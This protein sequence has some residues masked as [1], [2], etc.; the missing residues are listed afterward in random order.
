MKEASTETRKAAVTND[1]NLYIIGGGMAGLSAAI[2]A[3]KDAG[4]S[5]R[6]IHLFEA[7]DHQGGSLYGE[8]SPDRVYFTRGDWKFNIPTYNC[9]WDALSAIPSEDEPGMSV[10]EEIFQYNRFHKKNAMSRLIHA[11]ARR[12]NA[13]SLG[14]TPKHR[15]RLISLLFTPDILIQNRRV[16]SWFE[17]SF[18]DTNFWKVFFS[19]FA[20]EY[21]NDLAETKRY[22]QRFFHD[23]SDMVSGRAEIVTPYNNFDSM[24]M[25]MVK[26]LK[27][28]GVNFEMGVKVTD[29]DFKSGGKELTVE[30]I[31]CV[32]DGR[33]RAVEVREGDFVFATIGSMIADSRRGTMT[34]APALERGKTDGAWT[35]WENIAKKRPGLGNPTNFCDRIEESAWMMICVN[36]HDPAFFKAYE[37]FTGNKPGQANMV[38]FPDSNW[39]SSVL[40]PDHPHF[41]NQ[42][43]NV[44]IW[45]ACGLKPFEKGNFVK[46]P[47][48][49]CNGV[50]IAT[51]LLHHFGFEKELP[52]IIETSHIIPQMMPYEMSHFLT[53][54]IKDRPPA[55]PKGSTNLGLMGQFVESGE[56]VMLVESSVRSAMIGVYSLLGVDKKVPPVYSAITKDPRVWLKIWPTIAS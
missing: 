43:E 54:K 42:P 47:M 6:N 37:K 56:C 34:E 4:V 49:E 51:E 50:E 8:G 44:Y 27:G 3:I 29:F 21:W 2:F 20:I 35:L 1:T 16:D 15:R 53:R 45:L 55:V 9:L 52:K 10:K 22:M 31:H 19:M 14:L 17:P 40:V 48:T 24:T 11:G 25:P 41:R 33:E 46:K 28:H 5:G 18:F 39:H 13:E 32:S 38:T 23:L 12:D 30:R 7:L 26:W 36:G